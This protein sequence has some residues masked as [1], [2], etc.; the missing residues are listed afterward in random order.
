MSETVS[1]LVLPSNPA[2][3]KAIKAALQEISGSKTRAEAE[4]DYQKDTIA[5]ISEKYEL[6]KPLLNKLANAYHQSNRDAVVAD[7]E[8]FNLAYDA[9]FES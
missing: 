7:V 4:R 8:D 6:P 3:R 5:E 2:D 9:I 1:T